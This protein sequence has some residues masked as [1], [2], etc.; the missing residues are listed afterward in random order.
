MDLKSMD[1]QRL[2][3]NLDAAAAVVRASSQ[4]SSGVLNPD[5]P[6]IERQFRPSEVMEAVAER[7]RYTG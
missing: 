1:S 7:V 6:I 2:A 5:L 4:L 3:D